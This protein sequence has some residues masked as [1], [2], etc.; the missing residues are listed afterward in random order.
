MDHLKQLLIGKGESELF[1]RLKMANRHGLIAGA[2][3]TGKTI[4]LKVLAEQFSEQ[5]VPVFLADVKGDLASVA[6]AGVMNPKLNERIQKLGLEPFDF[7]TYP[8]RLWD[9]FGELGHP[10]RTT[11][12]EMGPL[13]LGRILGL[14]DT[15]E[16]ILNIVFRVADEQG[17]L[18]ID[19]KDLRAMLQH[20]GEN[21][22]EYTLEYGNVSKVSVGAIQRALLTLE[23]QGGDV[24]FAE[25]AFDINDLMKLDTY[26]HGIISVLASEKLMMHPTLY[27]TF[28]LWL[29]SELFEELPEVGDV[30]KPKLVFFFDEAHLLFADA[31]KALMDKIELVVR[32][33]RSKGVGVYFVTQN[34]IDIP[35]KVLGQ[36]GN[37]VQHAIRAYT[38]KDQKAITAMAETFRQNPSIDI[39]TTITDL[40]TG[41]ALVSMLDEEGRPT[42]VERAMIVP[43]HSLIGTL[44]P[45]KR[46]ALIE[47]SPFFYKYN[48]VVDKESAYEMLK[49]KVE[50]QAQQIEAEKNAVL[51]EKEKRSQELEELKLQRERARTEREIQRAKE[52]NASQVTKMAKSF[53]GTMSSSIGRE[54]A[55]GVFGSLLRR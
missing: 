50:H 5:G 15:Q 22:S 11:V 55:R 31:P 52:K 21:A 6:E 9:V 3:G 30:D 54:I 51:L 10:L 48:E 37:R 2:T 35:D 24:F 43:P 16:G 1:L 12:S 33:I 19:L 28:L 14:N 53:L 41:E 45:L 25:P 23:D 26:G 8:V 4:T 47:N 18:L 46:R 29:L 44:D 20:V 17:L 42:V 39:A 36:L 34:P 38:P 49:S 13:L 7:K 27:S 32:L 40:K